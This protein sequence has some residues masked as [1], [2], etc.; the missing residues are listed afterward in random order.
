MSS[1]VP[2]E[3]K[4]AFRQS[5]QSIRQTFATQTQTAV[6]AANAAQEAASEAASALQEC[7][8]IQQDVSL[9]ARNRRIRINTLLGE[10]IFPLV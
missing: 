7:R 9:T 10:N 2:P 6:T 4:E 5:V 1:Q 3:I 8:Q